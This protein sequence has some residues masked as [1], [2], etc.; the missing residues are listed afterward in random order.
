MEVRLQVER[1]LRVVVEMLQ[2]AGVRLVLPVV[3]VAVLAAV[4]P[5]P[6]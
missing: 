6:H 2:A 3:Q 5:Y 1:R 4:L